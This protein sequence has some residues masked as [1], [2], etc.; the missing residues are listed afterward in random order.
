MEAQP[1]CT[2]L[3]RLATNF[4]INITES[5]RMDILSGK[6]SI[7]QDISDLSTEYYISRIEALSIKSILEIAQ[8]GMGQ[9]DPKSALLMAQYTR[10]V[11]EKMKSDHP[12]RDY[13]IYVVKNDFKIL[14]NDW[15]KYETF[16]NTS[17]SIFSQIL[18]KT[19]H[20]L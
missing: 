14:Q 13:L 15:E 19:P 5:I 16:L 1:N 11:L 17:P 20:L 18:F 8:L 12:L 6:I 3:F 2:T 7:D 10:E 9:S 4:C